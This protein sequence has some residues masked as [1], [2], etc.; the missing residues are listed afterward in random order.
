MASQWYYAVGDDEK[1]PVSSQELKSLADSGQLSPTDQVWKEG[2]ADWAEAGKIPNLFKDAP[3]AAPTIDPAPAGQGAPAINTADAGAP[4]IDT[5]AAPGAPF[6]AADEPSVAQR[7]S[8]PAAARLGSQRKSQAGAVA[9]QAGKDALEAFKVMASNPV[10]GLAEA[11]QSL[12]ASRALAAGIVFGIV[13]AV[14]PTIAAKML[15]KTFA[16][17]ASGGRGMGSIDLEIDMYFKIFLV[18]LVLPLAFSGGCA[19]ARLVFGGKNGYD[20]DLFIASSSLL[21]M[22]LFILI[23][24]LVGEALGQVLIAI[25]VFALSTMILML[26]SG[27]TRIH[28]IPDRA[29]TLAVPTIIVV[30]FLGF[31]LAMKMFFMS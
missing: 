27:T 19:V 14:C 17:F 28:Q 2:M 11:Y 1:G 26:Y 7:A 13:F 23:T 5:G 16:M 6:I 29:A 4:A 31:Y 21:P 15:I 10:G 25:Y 12:G 22:G 20:S 24:G 18:A 3:S 8:G 9:Q 30:G